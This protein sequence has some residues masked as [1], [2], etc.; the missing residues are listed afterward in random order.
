MVAG[1]LLLIQGLGNIVQPIPLNRASLARLQPPVQVPRFDPSHVN[2][3]I[4]HL[5]LGGFHRAHMARYTHNL[6]EIRADALNWGI[7]GAGLMPSDQ[8]MRDSLSPQDN[9]YTLVERSS[10]AETV[11]VVGSLRDVMF[12]GEAS[13]S[14]R[15]AINQKQNQNISLTVTEKGYCLNR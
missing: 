13:A 4:V 14:L 9:L 12:A 3:G 10:A 1:S 2:A 8:R 7:I 15:Q 6:M 5:G 11:T